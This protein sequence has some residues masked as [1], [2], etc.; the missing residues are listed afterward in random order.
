MICFKVKNNLQEFVKI[1]MRV[2]LK[3]VQVKF[4]S[5]SVFWLEQICGIEP[6]RVLKT[7]KA[8]LRVEP[9]FYR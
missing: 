6:A 8:R 7:I 5:E 3:M 9:N 4:F 1:L 2:K